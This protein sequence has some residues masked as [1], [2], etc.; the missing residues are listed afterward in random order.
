MNFTR[1]KPVE[2]LWEDT[3]TQPGWEDR[4]NKYCKEERDYRFTVRTA[5]YIVLKNSKKVIVSREITRS[6]SM[7]DRISIPRRCIIS[8]TKL[9]PSVENHGKRK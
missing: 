4:I 5:G 1:D 6:N 8:I 7:G 9:E 3:Y 2:I